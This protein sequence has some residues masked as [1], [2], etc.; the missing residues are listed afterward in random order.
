MTSATGRYVFTVRIERAT[1]VRVVHPGDGS[2][3]RV[4]SK[5]RTIAPN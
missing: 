1:V 3:E 5:R 4:R 2:C